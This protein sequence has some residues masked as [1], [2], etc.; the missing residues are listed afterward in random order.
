MT[1]RVSPSRARKDGL[2]A[3][4]RRLELQR[5]GKQVQSPAPFADHLV[6]ILRPA[7]V[8]DPAPDSPAYRSHVEA[9]FHNAFVALCRRAPVKARRS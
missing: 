5:E 7:C 3:I 1:T 8:A 4:R 2:K 6:A 9:N